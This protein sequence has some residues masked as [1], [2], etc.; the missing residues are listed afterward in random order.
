MS[1]GQLTQ[2]QVI[3]EPCF[4]LLHTTVALH[5]AVFWEECCFVLCHLPL[6]HESGMKCERESVVIT[7]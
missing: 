2:Y 4:M 3:A 5:K 7:A 6:M 1:T